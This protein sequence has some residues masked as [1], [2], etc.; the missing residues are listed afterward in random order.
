M[1]PLYFEY[2]AAANL[3]LPKIRPTAV[4][5]KNTGVYTVDLSSELQAASLATSPA[6]SLSFV[7]ICSNEMLTT[8]ANASS[9]VFVVIK[10]SGQSLSNG[11][12]LK[13]ENGDVFTFPGK[14]IITHTG[15][16]DSTL[17]WVNDGPLLDYMG[18]TPEIDT[19]TATL[20]KRHDIEKHANTYNT[21]PSSFKRNRNGVLLANEA[22]KL[23]RTITPTLWTLYDI[24]HNN[25]IQLPHKH[26]SVGLD[27]CVQ[28]PDHGCYT[29]MSP[30]IDANNKLINP[31]RLD[32][33]TGQAFITPPGWWHE[34]HNE[35]DQDAAVLAVQDAGLYTYLR[36]LDI[37]FVH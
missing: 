30:S 20:Y 25:R 23:T 15:F 29:L 12:L 7:N 14:S 37:K 35:T 17:Y 26:N 13:W 32:W 21:A 33:K 1:S 2:T 4:E 3:K 27:L 11:K 5:N 6:M 19:F 28:A 8:K 16:E 31:I 22:C 24:L 34:H 18:V 36:T 9:H 10:G